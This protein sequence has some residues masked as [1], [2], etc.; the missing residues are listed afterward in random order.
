VKA[1]SIRLASRQS[2]PAAIDAGPAEPRRR[3]AY[4]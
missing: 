1:S 2:W 3:M 4:I